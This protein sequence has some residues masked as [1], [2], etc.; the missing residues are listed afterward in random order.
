MIKSTPL[1]V[2]VVTPSY[3]RDYFLSQTLRYVQ[4]QKIENIELRWFILDDSRSITQHL[5]TFQ[6]SDYIEYEWSPLRLALGKKRNLLNQKAALW[7]ADIVCSMDDDDWY[8]PQ[9]IT[10][11]SNFLMSSD[12]IEFV[13]SGRDF[14]YD[15]LNQQIL[16]IPESRAFS[17]CNGVLCYKAS[18]IQFRKYKDTA[19][20]AEEFHFLKNA[21]I[22]QYD[23]IHQLHLA[24]AH[25]QNTVSKKNYL[26]NPKYKSALQLT[27][28][29]MQLVDQHFYLN[30]SQ[31]YPP[32]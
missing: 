31:T 30:L 23:N 7:G 22:H 19:Q 2:A 27:D 14:Y 1:K 29:P 26:Q 32:P 4:H 10:E 5:S 28:F 8:G 16:E 25:P 21:K 6:N 9:Y 13:G 18:V 15:Y 24:L 11:M 20:F 12:E 3:E 17:S